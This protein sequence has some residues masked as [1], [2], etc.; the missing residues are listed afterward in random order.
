[1]RST[2]ETSSWRWPRVSGE[3]STITDYV[4]T[5]SLAANFDK[6][7]G[8][9]K[10]A[11]ETGSSRAAYLDGSFGSG[12]SHFM[13][14]LHAILSGDA[15]ARGK[16]G[17]ADVVAKHDPWLHGR[18]FLLVPYHLPDSQSLDAAIL[19][20]Y[21]AH[22][23]KDLP[24][25]AAARRLTLTTSSSRTRKDRPAAPW[26]RGVHRPAPGER[27]GSAE[28]GT[29]D[30]DSQVPRRGIQRAAQAARSAAGSSATS[31]PARIKRYARAVRADQ[32][33]YVP[34]DEGLSV[35][36]KHAKN[37]LGFDA[38]VLLLDE[39]VLWLAGY[40]GD[41]MKVSIEAQKVSKLV[42]SAELRA[43]RPGDQLRAPPARP[44]GPGPQ[45]RRRQR[46]HQPLRHA[47]VLGRP[48]RPHPRS[49]D[50]NLP[51]IVHERLLK[52]KDDR[53]Q[54]HA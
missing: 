48:V 24:R 8:L 17:L 29:P 19:G 3:K 25:Q 12:K 26:R 39:L 6:A 23:A 37:V 11:V 20:G 9:I 18:K 43:A 40:I 36:S 2:P 34:L 47:Q 7:L 31:S 15:D 13:A 46:G 30:W 4:V 51:A 52:P 22:V 10:S 1:M 44:A 49:T 53:R 27:R 21:V 14:V 41:H 33:S 38:I 42:E 5:D 32:E 45:G 35:I 28:W 50:N 16:K 54:G